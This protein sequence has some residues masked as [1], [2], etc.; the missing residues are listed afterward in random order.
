MKDTLELFIPEKKYV[1][2][3]LVIKQVEAHKLY[4]EKIAKSIINGIGKNIYELLY[5]YYRHDKKELKEIFGL[6]F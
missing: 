1:S 5:H 3:K 6:A 2:G 4:K